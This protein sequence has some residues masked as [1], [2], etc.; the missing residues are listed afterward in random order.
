MVLRILIMDTI[1]NEIKEKTAYQVTVSYRSD[2]Y[3][4][5]ADITE[6]LCFPLLGD[7]I[8]F[9]KYECDWENTISA[10]IRGVKMEGERVVAI[11]AL[12]SKYDGWRRYL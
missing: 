10:Q 7:A 12:H 5:G 6:L 3:R 8:K 4:D 1:N 11:G 9:A 2:R